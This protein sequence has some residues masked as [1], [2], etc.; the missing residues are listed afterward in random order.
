MIEIVIFLP[1]LISYAS[2]LLKNARISIGYYCS[3]QFL[4]AATEADHL[5]ARALPK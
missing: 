3:T 1:F 5:L 4:V 2:N